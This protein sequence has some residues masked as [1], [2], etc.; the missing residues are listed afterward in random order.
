MSTR[1]VS[2]LV[3]AAAVVLA[4]CGSSSGSDSAADSADVEGNVVAVGAA[5]LP[6]DA[7]GSL[8]DAVQTAAEAPDD[9]S[10]AACTVDRRTLE[11]ATVRQAAMTV[12]LAAIE[13]LE[14]VIAEYDG[15]VRLAK[16]EVDAGDNMKLAGRYRVRGFPTIILFSKGEEQGRFSGA[17]PA[18]YI[19]AF[20]QQHLPAA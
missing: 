15:A 20:I 6:D 4:S 9:A 16:L 12:A 8:G 17:H 13:R 2:V 7:G 3:L 1:P 14:R 5:P 10:A 11:L 19:R 18:P